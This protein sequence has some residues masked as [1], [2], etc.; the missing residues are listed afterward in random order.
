MSKA[1]KFYSLA[2]RN[3]NLQKSALQWLISQKKFIVLSC[4]I[5]LVPI[6][7]LAREKPK[8]SINTGFKYFN[9]NKNNDS[10]YQQDLNAVRADMNIYLSF[11][12]FVSSTSLI[13][14]TTDSTN[15]LIQANKNKDE[16]SIL[17]K[18]L[19]YKFDLNDLWS[20]SLGRKIYDSGYAYSFMPLD[21]IHNKKAEDINRII[22]G[23]NSLELNLFSEDFFSSL[24]L[25]APNIYADAEET[26]SY[27]NYDR[28]NRIFADTTNL[29]G[30]YKFGWYLDGVDMS[31]MLSTNAKKSYAAGFGGSIIL[32]DNL[33]LHG[34]VLKYNDYITYS[35][36]ID[37]KNNLAQV[38]T[39]SSLNNL[40]KPFTKNK[41]FNDR[42][43]LGLNYTPTNSLNFIFEIYNDGG[44]PSERFWQDFVNYN[45]AN[46]GTPYPVESM[47]DVL[48]KQNLHRQN[49]FARMAYKINSNS[50]L[51]LK[52]L[53]PM[54]K[55]AAGEI[56]SSDFSY[57][58]N[59]YKFTWEVNYFN[60]K[61]QT[62]IATIPYRFQTFISFN[63]EY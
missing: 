37:P 63:H 22:D 39:Q 62:S 17:T 23:K 25:Y 50:D 53:K 12:G 15:S 2:A 4:I 5:F 54:S 24:I 52:L 41:E 48:K 34:S 29:F 30:I 21:I 38:L 49:M 51:A 27:Q 40:P 58:F 1:I 3:L 45:Y 20:L 19:F 60:A 6:N 42:F 32:T 7:L 55:Y 14:E 61:K 46:D 13:Y 56:I 31:F 26:K 8:S 10:S 43:I 33:E 28:I 57:K 16:F 11:N 44:A 35:L 36:S 18:E 47:G 59:A 9:F